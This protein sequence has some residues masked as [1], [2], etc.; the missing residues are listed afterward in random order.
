MASRRHKT[1]IIPFDAE[2]DDSSIKHVKHRRTVIDA[3]GVEDVTKEKVPVLSKDAA[4]Y[5][6]LRF[7]SAFDRAQRDLA[8][9]T[10]LKL[11]QKFPMHL[12]GYHSA[13]WDVLTEDDAHNVKNFDEALSSFKSA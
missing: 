4:L 12:C 5:E 10:G 1:A 7:V 9:M 6:I 2:I 8:W 3:Q 11:Y 13:V